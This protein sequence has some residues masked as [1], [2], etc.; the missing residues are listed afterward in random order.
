MTPE[1][2]VRQTAK[3]TLYRPVDPSVV[4]AIS[5]CRT[6]KYSFAS[7]TRPGVRVRGD[8]FWKRRRDR[9]SSTAEREFFN[10]REIIDRQLQI[11]NGGLALSTE[12]GL[13][14]QFDEKA[15]ARYQADAWK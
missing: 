12:P 15:I 2:H 4:A 10:F 7:R 6:E 9:V 1:Y 13:G 3:I 5:D 8:K 14:Y 11:R